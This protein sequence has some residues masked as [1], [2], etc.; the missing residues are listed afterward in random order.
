[1]DRPGI[2]DGSSATQQP[3]QLSASFTSIEATDS[4]SEEVAVELVA[5]NETPPQQPG[6]LTAA[7]A[8]E[9][10]PVD[11]DSVAMT[12][13]SQP[14][15]TTVDEGPADPL[16]TDETNTIVARKPPPARRSRGIASHLAALL[17]VNNRSADNRADNDRLSGESESDG[18]GDQFGHPNGTSFFQIRAQGQHFCY[19]VDCSSSM[20]EENAIAIARAELN[21][22][23]LRLK[24]TK[25]FQIL[26][27]DSELHPMVS[28][29]RDL[30]SAND[31]NRRLARQFMSGQ[32]PNNR[33]LHR[34]ALLAALRSRPDVI[35]LLTD[36]QLPELSAR[37]L[38][39]LK[40]NN[41]R[42]TQINV[43]EFGKGAK[44]GTNWLD[45]LARD[46]RGLYRYKDITE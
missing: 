46:H 43:I 36:G 3:P 13:D 24:S 40:A 20:E 30:F 17:P 4:A 10:E 8:Q 28:G 42:R 9:S 2:P 31:A 1:M 32:Q 14:P 15:E 16:P 25:R 45:Q 22:S 38:Y 26:F 21:A 34:P 29:G 27:Y 23:L 7:D 35:F 12:A 6:P 11:R 19:V 5:Q 18:T 37:D 44:L 41:K 33:A 39:D